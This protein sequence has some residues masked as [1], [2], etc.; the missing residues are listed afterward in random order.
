MTLVVLIDVC[1]VCLLISFAI[2]KGFESTLPLAAFL[3][4]LFPVESQ[5]YLPGLFDLTTQRI[6]L[7]TLAGLYM[8]YGRKRQGSRMHKVELAYSMVILIAWMVVSS[9]NSV[10][11][12]V[13]LKSVL[14]QCLDLFLPY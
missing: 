12:T 6:V 4:I 1:A 14:S 9:A 5:I 8:I 13:S 7:I 2:R 3:L 10:V 11:P